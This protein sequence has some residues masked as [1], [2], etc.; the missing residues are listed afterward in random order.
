[1]HL[2]TKP[3]NS[4]TAANDYMFQYQQSITYSTPQSNFP[5]LSSTSPH[6]ACAKLSNVKYTFKFN[7]L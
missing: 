1:M 4:I 3:N 2:A 6:Y 7:L 5:N